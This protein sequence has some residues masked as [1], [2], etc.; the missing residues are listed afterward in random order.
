MKRQLGEDG[1]ATTIWQQDGAKPQQANM[2]MDYL[3]RVFEDRMLALKARRGESWA[4]SSPDL[5]PCD[6][7]LWG[8]MK[9]LVYKPLPTSLHQLK[10][11]ITLTFRNIPEPMVQKAVYGMKKRAKKLVKTGG[12]VFEGKQI[13]I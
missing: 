10:E 12:Q 9:E 7:F 8:Y 2:V 13:R 4:L 1:F 3:D 11:K 6:F 5:N